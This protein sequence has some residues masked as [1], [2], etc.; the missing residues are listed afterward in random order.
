MRI[1][2]S[3]IDCLIEVSVWLKSMAEAPDDSVF[4]KRFCE[5]HE[6]LRKVY[7]LLMQVSDKRQQGLEQLIKKGIADD[8][9]AAVAIRN[10]CPHTGQN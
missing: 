8:S 4:K 5:W 2:Q 3:D 1:E 6:R 7:I 9:P 10:L